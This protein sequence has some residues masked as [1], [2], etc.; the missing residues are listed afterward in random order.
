MISVDNPCDE[1]YGRAVWRSSLRVAPLRSSSLLFYPLRSSS[2]LFAPLRSSSLLFDS[3]RL[4]SIG[5]DVRRA[6]SLASHTR[7]RTHTHIRLAVPV[8]RDDD[9]GVGGRPTRARIILTAAVSHDPT[10]MAAVLQRSMFERALLRHVVACG[11]FL[12]VQ[13][14]HHSFS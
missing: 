3:L 7:A 1:R 6:R 8:S 12:V 4:P 11:V 5:R 14:G 9:D 10:T 13:V 2:L